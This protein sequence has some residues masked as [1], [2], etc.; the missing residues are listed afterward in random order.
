MFKNGTQCSKLEVNGRKERS[1][2]SSPQQTCFRFKTW[3]DKAELQS[4]ELNEKLRNTVPDQQT[5]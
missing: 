1:Q 3:Q 4:H 2:S 5:K